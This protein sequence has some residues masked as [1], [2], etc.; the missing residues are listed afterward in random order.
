MRSVKGFTLIELMVTIAVAAILI[1]LAVPSFRNF[2]VSSRLSGN[3]SDM[4]DVINFARSE[5]IKRN[6]PV[7]FCRAEDASATACK[8]DSGNWV[9]WVVLSGANV[10]RR[11]EINTY[12]GTIRVTSDLADDQ[13]NFGGDGLARTGGNLIVESQIT[14]CATDGPAESIRTVTFGAAS[15][16]STSKVQGVCQ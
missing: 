11:G 13:V 10:L 14:I 7:E 1:S 9:H 4:V 2:I 15:R 8:N 3:A 16:V 5:S 12:G 6:A